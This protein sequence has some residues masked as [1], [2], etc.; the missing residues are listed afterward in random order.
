MADVPIQNILRDARS[1]Q[2]DY[3]VYGRYPLN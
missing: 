3:G 1:R 2:K